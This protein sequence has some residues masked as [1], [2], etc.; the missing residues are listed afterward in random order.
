M[1]EK[2]Q[3]ITQGK[4]HASPSITKQRQSAITEIEQPKIDYAA[5]LAIAAAGGIRTPL[6]AQE[7]AGQAGVLMEKVAAMTAVGEHIHP[8]CLPIY[9]PSLDGKPFMG[10]VEELLSGIS[11]SFK[12]VCGGE[13]DNRL[14]GTLGRMLLMEDTDP[15]RRIIAALEKKPVVLLYF[16][17]P[18]SLQGR[19]IL[20]Q[21]H[22]IKELPA[23]F[24]G[25]GLLEAAMALAMYPDILVPT[26]LSNGY[27]CPV[28]S[29]FLPEYAPYFRCVGK[30]L[31]LDHIETAAAYTDYSGGIV[32]ADV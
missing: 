9:L 19:S 5:R 26:S 31:F 30:K 22:I 8:P 11:N 13:F 21:R 17:I 4:T 2:I 28:M 20:S 14:N 29:W 16:P 6:S 32:Y 1:I 7:F 15:A 12:R 27:S 23:G 3:T 25:C 10:L 24:M 18:R